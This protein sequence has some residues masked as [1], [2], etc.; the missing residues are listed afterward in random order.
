[1]AELNG[2]DMSR[3]WFNWSFENPEKVNPTHSAIYFFA[4]EHC[5][6]LGWK[7]KFGFPSQMV[8]DALGIKKHHTYIKY[9]DD[10]CEW[11]FFKLV[12]KSSNQYS[13]NIISLQNAM[14]KSGKAL[15][16]ALIKHAAKHA[17]KQMQSNGQ[18][19]GCIDKPL[20]INNKPLTMEVFDLLSNPAG[21]F[22][23]VKDGQHI[24]IKIYQQSFEKYLTGTFIQYEGQKIALK[25]KLP[26]IERFFKERNGEIY[27]GN[28]HLWAAFRKMWID[29]KSKTKERKFVA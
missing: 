10:L 26:P 2:Y 15:D 11:G 14:L 18:S 24:T 16:K 28:S 17:A 6:R 8:M 25:D 9:F 23:T 4:I 5:N 20:T 21:L 13:A 12:Q 3:A 7:E 29:E 27:S 22:V 19:S 1:M